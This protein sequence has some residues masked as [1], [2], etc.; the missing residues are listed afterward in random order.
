MLM[1]EITQF[2]WIYFVQLVIQKNHWSQ[3]DLIFAISMIM[4]EKL[5]ANYEFTMEKVSLFINRED[6]KFSGSLQ[7]DPFRR[8]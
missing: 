3:Q 4:R 5:T 2:I 1:G 7:S 6:K 8:M